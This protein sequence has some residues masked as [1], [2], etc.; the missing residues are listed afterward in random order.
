MGTISVCIYQ[1]AGKV[2]V[3]N[4][5]ISESAGPEHYVNNNRI[6]SGCSPGFSWDRIDFL[7]IVCYDAMFQFRKKKTH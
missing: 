5:D 4:W 2:M 3:I 7:H 1:R 6:R